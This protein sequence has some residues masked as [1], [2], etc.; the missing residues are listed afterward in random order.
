MRWDQV[1]ERLLPR[2]NVGVAAPW[3]VIA[4]PGNPI[5]R[6][7]LRMLDRV[8]IRPEPDAGDEPDEDAGW[9]DPRCDLLLA[10]DELEVALYIADGPEAVARIVSAA[11]PFTRTVQTAPASEPAKPD[12]DPPTS[13]AK[14]TVLSGPLTNSEYELA[15]EHSSIGGANDNDIVVAH[16]SIRRRHAE[17]TRDPST[18]R[19]CIAELAASNGI[20]VNDRDQASC[21]LE[22]GDI[23]DLGRVRM[24]FESR[25][26]IVF[27]E[28]GPPSRDRMVIV[29]ADPLIYRDPF[30]DIGAVKFRV[31]DVRHYAERGANLPLPKRRLLQA[32]LALLVVEATGD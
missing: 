22:D 28:P 12:L 8:S 4:V 21:A 31:S 9:R 15:R 16:R 23:I 24:R 3:L 6:L 1:K 25:G 30:V 11:A 10:R 20:R 26:D 17:V 19:Y 5:I 32:A 2:S 27:E 18:G 7:D 14:L 29:G 13:P